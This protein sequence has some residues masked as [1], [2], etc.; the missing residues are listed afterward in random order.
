MKRWN[1]ATGEMGERVAEDYLVQKGWQVVLRNFRTRYGEIDL[2]MQDKGVLVFVEVKTKKGLDFGTP[3]EMFTQA[4]Q[5]QVRRMAEVYLR[6]QE[7]ACRID[8]V[9]IQFSDDYGETVIKHYQ[10]AG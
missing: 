5:R 4:K 1:K 9:A 7:A 3:E 8:L 2:I 10:N 6:G